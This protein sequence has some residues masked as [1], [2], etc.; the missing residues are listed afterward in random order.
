MEGRWKG[1]VGEEGMLKEGGGV[2]WMKCI[3]EEGMSVEVGD[4][5]VVVG[6]VVEA[7]RYEGG[8][9]RVGMVWMDGGYG[10]VEKGRKEGENS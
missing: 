6:R 5:V 10:R 3:W 8:R 9:G 1:F 7:G 4:H 2:W